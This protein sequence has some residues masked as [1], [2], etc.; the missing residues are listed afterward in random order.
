MPQ[1]KIHLSQLNVG[2][3]EKLQVQLLCSPEMLYCFLAPL[4]LHVNRANVQVQIRIYWACVL[5]EVLLLE[6]LQCLLKRVQR[7][8]IVPQELTYDAHIVVGI[9]QEWMVLA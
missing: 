2:L 9:C 7:V 6:Y 1:T 4:L 3:V 5:C 8:L